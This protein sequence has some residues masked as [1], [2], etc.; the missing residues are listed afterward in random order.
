MNRHADSGVRL[1]E[2]LDDQDVFEHPHPAAA[3][4][5]RVIHPDEPEISR[6]LVQL[7]RE[8]VIQLAFV[9][10]FRLEF[11]FCKFRGCLFDILLL[12]GQGKIHSTTSI[13]QFSV[14]ESWNR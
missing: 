9:R 11:P 8:T 2:L 14:S 10:H 5:F 6:L 13:C 7:A 1:A 4:F 3:D 12:L